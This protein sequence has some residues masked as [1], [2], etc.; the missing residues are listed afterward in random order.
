MLSNSYPCAFLNWKY[1]AGY[2]AR[3]DI[4]AALSALATKAR[5]KSFKSC[6]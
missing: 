4:K 1:D 2:M 6:R 3:S 5:S